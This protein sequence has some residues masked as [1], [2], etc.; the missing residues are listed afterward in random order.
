MTDMAAVRRYDVDWLRVLAVLLLFV[1]HSARPFDEIGWH[2][3][4]VETSAGLIVFIGFMDQFHMPLFFLLSG[5]AAWFALKRRTKEAFVYERVLRLFVPL[6]FGA[7]LVAIPQ[8]YFERRYYGVFDGSFLAFLPHVF[9]RADTVND[10]GLGNFHLWFL[11]YL[12]YLTLAALPVFL[13]LR[14]ERGRA[15]I[16][17]LARVCGRAGGIFLF[18]IPLAVAEIALRHSWPD[19]RGNLLYDWG[20]ALCYFCFVVYGY[21]LVSDERFARATVRHWLAGLLLGTGAF[22]VFGAVRLEWLPIGPHSTAGYLIMWAAHGL[23]A[24]CLI[25]ACLGLGRRYLTFTNGALRYAVQAALPLYLL[26][27]TVI[28]GVA[29]YIVKWS[30]TMPTKYAAILIASLATSLALY[31]LAIKRVRPMRFMFGMRPRL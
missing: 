20:N 11:E 24:W 1:F 18:A 12:F 26:H 3:K 13:Y 30:A 22:L 5:A 15:L 8:M 29:F 17:R 6:V 19:N 31:E 27:Q 21:V 7:V 28:V 4:N 23:A 2:V 14:G 9:D 25:V 10:F 16:D